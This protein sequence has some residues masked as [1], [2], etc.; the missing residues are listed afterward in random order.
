MNRLG[1]G[2][3]KFDIIFVLM[4][5]RTDAQK[6]IRLV[7]V[8]RQVQVKDVGF[9]TRRQLD[10]DAIAEL[11]GNLITGDDAGPWLAVVVPAQ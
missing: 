7:G 2:L 1:L 4:P 3:D 5:F 11:L 9:L 8:G 6:L 10:L